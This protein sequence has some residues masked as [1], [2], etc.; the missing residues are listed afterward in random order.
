MITHRKKKPGMFSEH[1]NR[2]Q[3]SDCEYKAD[4]IKGLGTDT[5]DCA[6]THVAAAGR[7]AIT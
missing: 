3:K 4:D 5:D 2:Q 6:F 7:K 1:A